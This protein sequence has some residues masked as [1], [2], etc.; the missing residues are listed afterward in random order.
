[1]SLYG[2]YPC[3]YFQTKSI[4]SVQTVPISQS[5]IY[6]RAIMNLACKLTN[7]KLPPKLQDLPCVV[8]ENVNC[9][10]QVELIAM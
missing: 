1:M 6:F 5:K 3:F 7:S 2:K 8:L 9:Q 4:W 10:T